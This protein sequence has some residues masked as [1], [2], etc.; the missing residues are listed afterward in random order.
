MRYFES[1]VQS[2]TKHS[3]ELPADA[4][5]DIGRMD[6]EYSQNITVQHELLLPQLYYI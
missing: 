1:T 3:T 2:I 5:I 6:L 4:P